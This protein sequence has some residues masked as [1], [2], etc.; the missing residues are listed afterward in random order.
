MPAAVP[1]LVQRDYWMMF[2]ALINNDALHITFTDCDDPAALAVCA[3]NLHAVSLHGFSP[4]EDPKALT[5]RFRM[6]F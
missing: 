1:G 5:D 2:E 4:A 3:Y 6:R